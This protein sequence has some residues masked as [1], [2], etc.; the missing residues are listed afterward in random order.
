MIANTQRQSFVEVANVFTPDSESRNEFWSAVTVSAKDFIQKHTQHFESFKESARALE[1]KQDGLTRSGKQISDMEGKALRNNNLAR[2]MSKAA[3]TDVTRFFVLLYSI[4]QF[5]RGEVSP[6]SDRKLIFKMDMSLRLTYRKMPGIGRIRMVLMLDEAKTL[7]DLKYYNAFRWVLDNV[8]ER[9]WIQSNRTLHQ[10]LPFLAVFLGTNSKVVD[11]L[12]PGKD[13]SH[14]YY[15]S[16]IKVPQPFTALDWDVY[17]SEPYK[18]PKLHSGDGPQNRN[19]D[20]SQ[21]AHALSRKLN[22]LHLAEIGWLSRFGRPIW[23]ALWSSYAEDSQDTRR[24]EGRKIIRFAENKLHQ[25]NPDGGFYKLMDQYINYSRAFGQPKSTEE[26]IL[27]CS[28]ILA[29]LLGLDLDLT[30][31]QRAADLVASRLRWAAGCDHKRTYLLT[32]YPSEPILAEAAFQLFFTEIGGTP[33]G[34][35]HEAILQAVA[36]EVVKGDYDIGGDG[37]LAARLLC[38]MITRCICL[39]CRHFC[40]I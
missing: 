23:N 5:S 16:S 40:E 21:I 17:V 31:P 38:N 11:F 12:P 20:R 13:A 36:K 18:L 14:R 10:P 7:V 9:A 33:G 6:P 1:I 28:A 35:A 4:P 22:Y 2:E 8:V 34:P 25:C 30:S 39:T 19:P 32:T 27:T 29:V 37:E 3:A 24:M 26:Y 15:A